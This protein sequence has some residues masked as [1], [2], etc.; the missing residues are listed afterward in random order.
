[1]L[2]ITT[3]NGDTLIHADQESDAM[4][5]TATDGSQ[6]VV[7]AGEWG[8]HKY[9]RK[10]G[11]RYIYPE[12]LQKANDVQKHR[13]EV[14]SDRRQ[15]K[16]DRAF[17]KESKEITK[18]MRK[19]LNNYGMNVSKEDANQIRRNINTNGQIQSAHQRTVSTV[20]GTYNQERRATNPEAAKA[21]IA[22]RRKRKEAENRPLRVADQQASAHQTS[23][24]KT[25]NA[26]G[27]KEM[28]RR[29][30]DAETAKAQIKERREKKAKEKL[31]SGVNNMRRNA[32]IRKKKIEAEKQKDNAHAIASDL[33]NKRNSANYP[34]EGIELQKKKTAQRKKAKEILD[35]GFETSSAEEER[36]KAGTR[37]KK[38]PKSRTR[39]VL[40]GSVKIKKGSSVKI[41]GPVGNR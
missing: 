24:K 39:N 5:F 8:R 19:E 3:S 2:K 4:K 1:M 11:N 33:T 36:K 20:A 12:D 32:E 28:W 22:E 40:N 18:V 31:E 35:K 29:S 14:L 10:E 17:V 37:A 6:V 7:H 25:D 26:D 41:S 34:S 38:R 21:Q 16:K 9:I 23:I 30:P 13:A 27:S 15:A